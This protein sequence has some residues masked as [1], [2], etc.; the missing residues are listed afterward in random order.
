MAVWY[1]TGG[2]HYAEAATLADSLRAKQPFSAAQLEV[3]AWHFKGYQAETRA[4]MRWINEALRL[5]STADR[6][7]T[8]AYLRLLT[9]QH[10]EAEEACKQA[11][12]LAKTNGEDLTLHDLLLRE[13]QAQR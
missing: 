5:E 1:L 11:H 3:L 13:L 7:N 4:A 8:K 10:A 12:K 9:K 6:L 2:G